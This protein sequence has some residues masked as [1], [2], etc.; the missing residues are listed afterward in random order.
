MNLEALRKSFHTQFLTIRNCNNIVHSDDF[1]IAFEAST[2]SERKR[3]K[4]ILK[5]HNRMELKKFINKKLLELTPFERLGIR[6]LRDIGKN[7]G[8]QEYWL[9]SKVDLLE[10]IKTHVKKLKDEC[11]VKYCEARN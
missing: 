11:N 9:K 3:L 2:E 10:E 6:R 5:H 1:Q 8:I 4:L 7:I